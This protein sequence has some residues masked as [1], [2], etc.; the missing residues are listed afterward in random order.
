MVGDPAAR[1]IGELCEQLE[2]DFRLPRP[3][4]SHSGVLVRDDGFYRTFPFTHDMSGHRARRVQT[5]MG[6]LQIDQRHSRIA[7]QLDIVGGGQCTRPGN[8]LPKDFFSVGAH[9][10]MRENICI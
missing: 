4:I 9:A 6:W 7:V 8:H 10:T 3:P 1:S 2:S 5:W